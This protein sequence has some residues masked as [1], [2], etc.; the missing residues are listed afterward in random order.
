VTLSQ[1]FSH[2]TAAFTLSSVPAHH[3]FT[4]LKSHEA[5]QTGHWKTMAS[6]AIPFSKL[7]RMHTNHLAT[8]SYYSRLLN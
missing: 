4:T 8:I 5:V 1:W 7:V 3:F 2:K 6:L